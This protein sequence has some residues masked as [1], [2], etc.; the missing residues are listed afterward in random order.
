MTD[1]ST[2]VSAVVG[3]FLP[4]VIAFV[5]GR[6]APQKFQAIFAFAAC[7]GAAL[8]VTILTD[9]W[10]NLQTKTANDVAKLILINVLTVLLVAWNFF[11]RLY[12]PTGIDAKLK[13]T[14]PQIGA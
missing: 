5:M 11:S 2:L 7:V 4:L 12:H 1:T 13:D 9:G 10:Q 3:I 6:V 8:I 14:G